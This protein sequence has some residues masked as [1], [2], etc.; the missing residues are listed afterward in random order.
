MSHTHSDTETLWN[1]SSYSAPAAA[2]G[3]AYDK[4]WMEER[5]G[6]VRTGGKERDKEGKVY[7]GEERKKRKKK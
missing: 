7:G 5:V 6:R 1:V 3:A 4:R 2:A